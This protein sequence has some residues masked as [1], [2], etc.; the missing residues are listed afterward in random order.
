[1]SLGEALA[2]AEKQINEE[3]ELFKEG[4]STFFE[5]LN[6]NSDM[7]KAQFE[8]EKEGAKFPATEEGRG[9]GAILPDESE[10]YTSPELEE[11]YASRQT[12][13]DSWDASPKGKVRLGEGILI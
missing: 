7:T 4:K 12:V 5:K 8:K 3:N 2:K 1:M 9:L 11:L 10:W 6:K 13:P